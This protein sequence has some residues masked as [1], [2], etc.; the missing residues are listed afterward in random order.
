M[1]AMN[2]SCENTAA[3]CPPWYLLSLRPRGG[4]A[5]MR[6][7]ATRVGGRVLALS[8]WRL[9]PRDDDLT[10]RQLALA[11]DAERI[12]FTS[13]A[14]VRAAAA[15]APLRATAGGTLLAV[16]A[17]TA[18]ALH[19]HGAGQVLAPSRMDSEGL[20]ALPALAALQGLRAGLVTAPGGR[21]LIAAQ[22]Q[23]RGATL[24]R[25]DVYERIAVPLPAASLHRLAHLRAPAVLAL[26]SGEALE[27]VLPQLTPELLA[28]WRRMPVVAAG[29]RLADHARQSGFSHVHTA[30]G[31]MPRQLA[32]AARAAIEAM[33]G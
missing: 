22:L 19:R 21:G 8:P 17:G 6:R 20:L 10:R 13:P 12:I 29:P 26:S 32:D 14:A 23:A 2:D 30:A 15:L 11:L 31:P 24:I 1:P 27:R 7:A 9:Q 33:Q 4:H 28:R 18:G 5:A 3:H 25:A 16:G